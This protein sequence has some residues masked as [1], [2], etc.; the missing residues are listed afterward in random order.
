MPSLA[1]KAYFVL[2]KLFD[3]FLFNIFD[4]IKIPTRLTESG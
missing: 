4:I 3:K 1:E 2:F